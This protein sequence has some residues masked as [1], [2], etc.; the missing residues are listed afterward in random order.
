MKI[1][2]QINIEEQIILGKDTRIS[3]LIPTYN[4][5]ASIKQVIKNIP[6]GMP[7]VF[8]KSS[9]NTPFLAKKAGAIVINRTGNGKGEAVRE[10]ITFLKPR[11]DIIIMIDGDNTYDPSE[12]F[13]LL[14]A[15]KNGADMVTGSRFLGKQFEG[16]M[17]L[18][19][20][21]GNYIF[22]FFINVLFNASLTD[23]LTGFRAFY[24]NNINPNE[25][26]SK[27]FDIEVELTTLF[28]RKK[29]NIIEV[30]I[31]F[32]KR[33]DSSNSKWNIFFDGVKI[34]YSIFY[35]F[36]FNK[37]K[38]YKIWKILKQLFYVVERD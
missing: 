20:R 14:S 38:V 24:V 9:D 13:N 18:L 21:L 30:P 31:S 28:L 1:Y 16:A 12:V 34:L 33:T 27:G 36:I 23:F 32:Y 19:N 37:N 5:E 3:W 2:N 8:D 6:I 29:L 26:F 22:N 7:Y 15:L 35:Y 4:E 25:L 17:G 11:S 10:G